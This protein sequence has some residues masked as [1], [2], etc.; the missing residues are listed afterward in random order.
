MF[1]VRRV[2]MAYLAHSVPA[3]GPKVRSVVPSTMPRRYRMRQRE[4]LRVMAG[5]LLAYDHD[6][7]HFNSLIQ[8]KLLPLTVQPGEPQLMAIV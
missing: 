7:S 8:P 2:A 5:F 3:L 4:P 6:I 1:N